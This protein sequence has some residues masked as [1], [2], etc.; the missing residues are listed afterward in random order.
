MRLANNPAV[1]RLEVSHEQYVVELSP[2]M[3]GRAGAISREHFEQ[4]RQ[5]AAAIAQ[6]A[7]ATRFLDRDQPP[8][9]LAPNVFDLHGRWVVYTV[10]PLRG[11]VQ[12]EDVV[13]S[14]D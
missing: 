2:R 4:L 14:L 13:D 1:R 7:S 3:W 5:R 10:D 12:I 6:L 9:P 8:G 11:C